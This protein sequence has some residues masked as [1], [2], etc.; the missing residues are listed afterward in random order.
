MPMLQAGEKATAA[1]IAATESLLDPNA[2]MAFMN[3][4]QQ[5]VSDEILPVH[6][7]FRPETLDS[8]RRTGGWLPLLLLVDLEPR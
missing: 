4:Y 3:P 2:A 6:M 7:T 5:A 8:C 1:G